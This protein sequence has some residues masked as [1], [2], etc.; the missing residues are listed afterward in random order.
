V[1]TADE[2][3]ISDDDVANKNIPKPNH[4][5][6]LGGQDKKSSIFIPD[7]DYGDDIIFVE[8]ENYSPRKKLKLEEEKRTSV[9]DK[10]SLETDSEIAVLF[11]RKGIDFPHAREHCRV[12]TFVQTSSTTAKN[13]SNEEFCEKCYCYV[14]DDLSSK[15][16]S[17]LGR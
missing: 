2:I 10:S 4:T 7:G 5:K 12:K 1:I 11:D 13:P 6:M 17:A 16:S 15:V 14:C 8:P 3:I 9:V